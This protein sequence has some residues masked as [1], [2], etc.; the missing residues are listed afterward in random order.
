MDINYNNLSQK[1]IA[2]SSNLQKIASDP[3]NSCF[4]FASA[5][6]GKTKILT[7]RVLRL[8]LSGVKSS[9]I[10]CLTFTKIAA[11][12]MKERIL[13][14]LSLW[15]IIPDSELKN[16]LQ[17]LTNYNFPDKELS[18]FRVIFIDI[19]D[20][21]SSLKIETIHSFCN[22]LIKKFPIEAK[23]NPNFS[24]I[25]DTLSQKLLNQSK[26]QLLKK[27]IHNSDIGEKITQIIENSGDQGLFDI[28]FDI[29]D[30][31]EIFYHLKNSFQNIEDLSQRIFDI[32][33]AHPQKNTEILL[34]DFFNFTE[35][36][37]NLLDLCQKLSDFPQQT[38]LQAKIYI[39]KYILDKNYDNFLEYCNIFLTKNFEPKKLIITKKFLENQP[40]YQDIIISE[41]ARILKI[42]E[43][44]N[45]FKIANQTSNIIFIANEILEIYDN[46]KLANGYL[47]YKDLIIKT[48]NLLQDNEN[49][50]WIKYKLDNL[51]DHILVDESQDT[52]HL[53]WHIIKLIT[54]DFFDFEESN[55]TIFAVGD[56]KQSIYGFQGADPNIFS[57]IFTY[58]QSKFQNIGKNFQ[59]ITL[60]NSFRSSNA[61]LKAVDL[62]FLDDFYAKKISKLSK[63]QHQAIRS[64]PG[65]VEIWPII[66]K[67][68]TAIKN[69]WDLDFSQNQQKSSKE[70]LAIKIAKEI[71]SWI[72]N[73]K[74]IIDKNGQNR[75]I[76]YR[77]IMIL[78]KN[79]TNNLGNLIRKYLIEEKI[80]VA[81]PDKI[82]LTNNLLIQDIISLLKF[83]L[84]PEDD[85]NL[86]CLLKSSFIALEEEKLL[87][88]CH[89]KNAK[90]TNLIAILQS[91]DPENYHFL[92]NLQQK[93][94]SSQNIIEFLLDFL[95]NDQIIAKIKGNFGHISEELLNYFKSLTIDYQNQEAFSLQEFIH[96]IESNTS[97]VSLENKTIFNEVRIIT[98]HSSKGLEAPIV[99]LPDCAHNTQN[100]KINNFGNN[101]I[102]YQNKIPI[103]RFS[104]ENQNKFL[105]DIILEQEE[106]NYNEY[107]RLLYVAMTR[108]ENELYICGFNDGNLSENSWYNLITKAISNKCLKENF[109]DKELEINDKKLLFCD[110]FTANSDN[111]EQKI[112]K[113]EQKTV[114]IPD[115][116]TKNIPTIADHIIIY[117][118]KIYDKFENFKDNLEQKQQKSVNIGKITHKILEF[119][120]NLGQN[121]EKSLQIAQKYLENQNITGKNQKIILKNI[122]NIIENPDFNF[123]FSKNS[124][125][126]VA[127]S[128]KIDNKIISGQID[129][130]ILDKNSVI[131]IDYKTNLTKNPDLYQDQLDSYKKII[132]K[133]YPNKKIIT[134]IIWTY[135]G[136]IELM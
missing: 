106:D 72:I 8:L 2:E 130:L 57:D 85:L 45:S 27:A 28:I 118:S 90:K 98:I 12:E 59:E 49:S 103:A 34:N 4:I 94:Q 105:K 86:S 133:I 36:D 21:I 38:N 113:I 134:A 128:A 100:I 74:N 132:T 77:D 66:A 120:P 20:D 65:K 81:A 114:K 63:V 16:K 58:Y 75:P 126:E 10:L 1:L 99:F 37:Q 22:N 56:E 80:P 107:L 104:K 18:N 125:S 47:D 87:E 135:H 127:I 14:E 51:Y 129:R 43:K 23:V 42:I 89:I 109:I 26:K 83:I 111:F 11:L 92:Q 7:D 73:K 55:R 84:L 31:R 60:N 93:Y 101:I 91:N 33:G 3:N 52:N 115:F 70:I 62:V 9:K 121:S 108:A 13:G 136:E 71:K 79:R 25:D 69:A 5:G 88:L 97:N 112:A 50:E 44:L 110:K 6:S 40:F 53:Q 24:I 67:E 122:Q 102:W 96:Q 15:C 17:K 29:I 95:S 123:L 116:L 30:K 124:R 131:I 32:I 48:N 78:L 35:N 46:L 39:E 117:P 61:I 41:Q 119:L 54:D 76:Q 82:K 64:N 68:K 19:L